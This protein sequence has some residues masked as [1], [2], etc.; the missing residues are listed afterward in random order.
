MTLWGPSQGECSLRIQEALL[1]CGAIQ[2]LLW[3]RVGRGRVYR[4]D[5]FDGDGHCISLTNG[6]RKIDGMGVYRGWRGGRLTIDEV[7]R[8]LCFLAEHQEEWTTSCC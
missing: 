3:H 2:G 4:S 1:Y 8:E 7:N 6:I 5:P